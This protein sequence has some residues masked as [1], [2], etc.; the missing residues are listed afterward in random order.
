MA[1]R[2]NVPQAS[3]RLA[4]IALGGVVLAGLAVG[5]YVYA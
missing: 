5:T 4:K 3:W 2:N 1:F